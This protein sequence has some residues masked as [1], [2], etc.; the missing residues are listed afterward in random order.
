VSNIELQG[1]SGA[2]LSI[3]IRSARAVEGIEAAEPEL[4]C[5]VCSTS[6]QWQKYPHTSFRESGERPIASIPQK[7][8]RTGQVVHRETRAQQSASFVATS[9][10]KQ[11]KN[12]TGRRK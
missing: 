3:G 12:R 1:N 11:H 5:R 8:N 7:L 6:M 9:A 2:M 10:A 4:D